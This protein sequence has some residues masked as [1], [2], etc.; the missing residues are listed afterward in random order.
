MLAR[1]QGL[2]LY[3]ATTEAEQIKFEERAAIFSR[4]LPYAMV[5]GLVD[6]WATA[7]RDIGSQV[8]G[9]GA[10]GLY[11][12]TGLPGWSMF[13]FAQS[14]GSFATTTTGTIAT[15]SPPAAGGRSGFGSGGFSGGGF[16]GGGGGSW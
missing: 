2:R 9:G 12:Y 5:F 1:V 8:E 4:Y 16:G 3:I 11:W 14:I 15:T 7:F 6:R 10:P 13:Y